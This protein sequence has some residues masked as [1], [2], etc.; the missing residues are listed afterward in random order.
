MGIDKIIRIVALLAA[1]ALA[2]VSTGQN[3]LILAVVGLVLGAL[4][5][6][7]DHRKL[8]LIALIALNV[9]QASLSSIPV[10]GVYLTD[11]LGNMSA[12]ANAAGVVV[13]FMMIKDRIMS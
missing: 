9:V 1:V 12:V 6:E 4:A 13:I 10:V 8:F 3:A 2:F 7:A 5:V 11:I